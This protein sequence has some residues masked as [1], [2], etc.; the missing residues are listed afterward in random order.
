[1]N[2]TS[3]PIDRDFRRTGI[4]VTDR[5]PAALE[6]LRD[7]G[8]RVASTH[9]ELSPVMGDGRLVVTRGDASSPLTLGFGPDGRGNMKLFA[10]ATVPAAE[11]RAAGSRLGRVLGTVQVLP[12]GHHH[13]VRRWSPYRLE[14]VERSRAEAEGWGVAT[15]VGLLRELPSGAQRAIEVRAVSMPPLVTTVVAPAGRPP[16]VSDAETAN[17]RASVAALG[18][19]LATTV[20][21][22]DRLQRE[23]AALRE[24]ASEPDSELV[25]IAA[26]LAAARRETEISVAL[27]G[28]SEV[29]ARELVEDVRSARE[30]AAAREA[31]RDAAAARVAALEAT[32]A[33]A[34]IPTDDVLVHHLLG[35]FNAII[36]SGARATTC[37]AVL[38][39]YVDLAPNN[40]QLQELLGVQL[41]R[42]DQVREA[43][44]VLSACAGTLTPRGAAAL[45]E[46]A[47]RSRE[48]PN[49]LEVIARVDWLVGK[50]A[51]QLREV[52]RWLRGSDLMRLA[53]LVAEN[54]PADVGSFL[55]EVARV[56]TRDQMECLFALWFDLDMDAALGQLVDWARSD[57]VQVSEAWV[58]SGLQVA[59]AADERRTIRAAL[60]LLASDAERSRDA[61]AI[62]DL[63]SLAR[64]KLRPMDG[65]EFAVRWLREGASVAT[66]DDQAWAD[67]AAATLRD[68]LM[69]V[70]QLREDDPEY[71]LALVLIS[72]TSTDIAASLRELVEQ[73]SQR[74]DAKTRDITTVLEALQA[75]AD[76]FPNLVI[77]AEAEK[78][79]AHRGT[80]G[81]KKAR[82]ALFE[83][84][85]IARRYAGGNLDVGL[86]EALA[87]LPDFKPDISDTAK[88][89]YAKEY[90]RVLPGGRRIVLGPH[91]DIGGEDGRAYI[92]VDREA[93]RLVLG[94]CGNHLRGK[95]D[96]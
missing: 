64:E 38:R 50:A 26:E 69:D 18:A 22:R 36:D 57:R 32:S 96:N 90:G 58:R 91:F 45:T 20:A 93:K 89:Q 40:P 79:A 8:A 34:G 82:E 46:A 47:F 43:V 76:R 3:V 94:H 33:T 62:V 28:A 29:K 13:E 66:A 7:V 41:L 86:D 19:R 59:V 78:S 23:V 6:F 11:S 5:L 51:Q 15:L 31:E 39:H 84:G 60:D 67:R 1:M 88:R 73:R 30:T 70:P 21:E 72:R 25:R 75:T 10:A 95:R 53:D 87:T 44:R 54:A 27:A 52:S 83:L 65:R 85:D 12:N 63:V 48:L 9:P 49:P 71:E 14:D 81:V 17:L 24:G 16:L 92:Y 37:L 4:H 55:T 35:S 2:G 42:D 74:V 68:V 77:L 80:I 61:Y 56:A